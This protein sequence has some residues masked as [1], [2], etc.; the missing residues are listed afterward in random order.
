[1]KRN[2]VF[3]TKLV[4]LGKLETFSGHAHA[5]KQINLLYVVF[6]FLTEN[7]KPGKSLNRKKKFETAQIFISVFKMRKLWDQETFSDIWKSYSHL[8]I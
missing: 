6:S 1:M 5:N 7:L 8:M 2:C 3:I 4:N